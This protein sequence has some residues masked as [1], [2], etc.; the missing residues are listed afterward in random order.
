MQSH[1]GGLPKNDRLVGVDIGAQSLRVVSLCAAKPFVSDAVIKQQVPLRK[2]AINGAEIEDFDEVLRQLLVVVEDLNLQ[3]CQAAVS[4]PSTAVR[5]YE[6]ACSEYQHW[7]GQPDDLVIEHLVQTKQLPRGHWC[8]DWSHSA[9]GMRCAVVARQELV[10][11][12]YA[13]VEHALLQP[14]VLDLDRTAADRSFA[15]LCQQGGL[16]PQLWIRWSDGLLF[17]HLQLDPNEGASV[18]RYCWQPGDLVGALA[19]LIDELMQSHG[20]VISDSCALAVRLTGVSDIASG[21]MDVVLLRW[22]Q[23]ICVGASEQVEC[24]LL[25]EEGWS[26]AVGL[27]LHPGLK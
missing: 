12:R 23:A 26:V 21:L 13:L 25:L 4:F 27:A 22:P 14:M 20:H 18:V 3:G 6:V 19:L 2:G 8:F 11:D 15:W 10:M 17:L 1:L 9:Q 16:W 7:F 24:K 5:S